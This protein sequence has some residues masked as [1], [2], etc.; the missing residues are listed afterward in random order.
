VTGRRL[1]LC[2]SIVAALAVAAALDSRAAGP[3]AFRVIVN[4]Q[5]P[6]TVVERRF[7]AD[8]F[9]KKTTRW[10]HDEVIRPADL[11][12]DAP[13]R[14]AFSDDLL[15]RS[16]AAVKNYWQQQV[17]SGRDVPPPELDSDQEMIK[18]VLRYPGA[19]GYVSGT[20]NVADA[21]ILTVK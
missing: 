4:P 9:L 18:Y 2:S 11:W 21:K 1:F 19:V 8:A 15:K 13:A 17:F 6:I 3:P 12:P 7:L 5:N 14:H 16:V 10:A 20:A